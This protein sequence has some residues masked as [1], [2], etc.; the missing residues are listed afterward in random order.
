M[1]DLAH[2]HVG[3]LL[4][5]QGVLGEQLLEPLRVLE[6]Q[7]GFLFEERRRRRQRVCAKKGRCIVKQACTPAASMA[8]IDRTAPVVAHVRHGLNAVPELHLGGVGG[9]WSPLEKRRADEARQ[10]TENLEFMLKTTAAVRREVREEAGQRRTRKDGIFLMDE[11]FPRALP[12]RTANVEESPG[13]WLGKN[14]HR[15]KR[16]CS[17]AIGSLLKKLFHFLFIL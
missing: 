13:S 4:R 15:C 8:R 1:H 3:L 16:G 6:V 5:A 17:W 12:S 11:G 14:E 2:V 9:G 7:L 10:A